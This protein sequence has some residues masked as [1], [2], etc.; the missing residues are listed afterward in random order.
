M[1]HF[2]DQAEYPMY[3]GSARDLRDLLASTFYK[4][5]TIESLLRAVQFPL[6]EVQWGETARELWEDVL[7]KAAQR[8]PRG[9]ARALVLSLCDAVEPLGY[10][11]VRGRLDEAL[12]ARPAVGEQA[13][14]TVQP[15]PTLLE[16]SLGFR[17]AMVDLAFMPSVSACSPAVVLL[18]VSFVEGPGVGSGFLIAPDLVITNEH[19]LFY[20]D[21]RAQQVEA[22]LGYERGNGQHDVV[23]C[24]AE[25]I[26]VNKEADI[27][28]LRLK[29]P[30]ATPPLRWTDQVKLE[31]KIAI[32]QHPLG[33]LKKVA[34]HTVVQVSDERLHYLADTDLGSSGAPVL[35]QYGRVVAVHHATTTVTIGGKQVVVNVGIR[36][37]YAAAV[38]QRLGTEW[39]MAQ[40]RT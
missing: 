2:L 8:N 17:S 25:T 22:W 33:T 29:R 13:V 37:S 19:V 5:S 10:G 30:L 20:K 28:L 16:K 34:F 21:K 6:S 4:P 12:S 32:V 7:V 9:G 18:S 23:E 1:E 38:A 40:P 39:P 11:Y 36:A 26:L 3:L 31:D 14:R 27:G 35:D 24:S 15:D